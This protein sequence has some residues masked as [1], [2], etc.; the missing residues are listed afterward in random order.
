MSDQTD[1]RDRLAFLCVDQETAAQLRAFRALVEPVLPE[2]LR[3]FYSH[4]ATQTE[5]MTL[6]GKDPATAQKTLA[7]ARAAQQ[8]HWLNLFSG[9]FDASYV[10]SVRRIGLAHSRIG[11]EPRWYIGGYA[12]TLNRLSDLVIES[13]RNLFKPAVAREQA[14]RMMAA[15]NKAVMLD[16]DLA[17]SI[18]IEENKNAYDARLAKLAE[19]FETS[20]KAVADVVSTSASDMKTGAQVMTESA[21]RTSQLA[22]AVAAASSQ[23]SSDVQSVASATEELT[24]SS[25]E[26]GMQMERARN[27]ADAAVEEAG[28]SSATVNALAQAAQKIGEIVA[29]IMDV[30]DQT[31]LLALNATIEAARAGEAGK[32]FAVVAG[33]VKALAGQTAKATG[34]IK[35][36]IADIQQAT[37]STVS[38][39]ESVSRTIGQVR[40][41]SAG[42]A[43]AVQEQIAATG[44]I[45][46][47]VQQVSLGTGEISSNIAGVT[48]AAAEAG[49]SS[50]S[51]M[52]G[53][54]GLAMQSA[55]LK[56]E[57]ETFLATLR[58][59]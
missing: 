16:M 6:F 27:F 49:Q 18:Y 35:S 25:R 48:G 11:L 15:V 12:F 5:L 8:E 34:E 14:Q 58:A 57:V 40:E 44:E 33:E 30:A 39:I 53:A 42:I 46:R 56:S 47:S 29:L 31:N 32:G 4:L 20:V 37:A 38:A 17:I 36:Q 2:I 13:C 9:K 51:L 22:T 10:A 3:D 41:A 45:A 23:A 1:I 24:A 59:A 21:E 28:R 19:G 55:R 43:A 52:N 50:S 26:I 7:H 54:D